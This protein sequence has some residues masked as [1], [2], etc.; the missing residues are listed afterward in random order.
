MTLR[1]KI[2]IGVMVLAMIVV[3]AFTILMAFGGTLLLWSMA[4]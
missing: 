2:E 4:K 3:F 1:D